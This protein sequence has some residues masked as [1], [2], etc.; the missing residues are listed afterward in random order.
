MSTFGHM[1]IFSKSSWLMI[2]I[3]SR[4]GARGPNRGA[5]VPDGPKTWIHGCQDLGS[6]VLGLGTEVPVLGPWS[7]DL[8]HVHFDSKSVI[9]I[10][11]HILLT[12]ATNLDRFESFVMISFFQEAFVTFIEKG[13][14]PT[15]WSTWSLFREFRSYGHF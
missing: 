5:R 1:D 6:M 12:S 4:S 2:F 3:S 10:L 11:S 9:M 14:F 7:Q 13:S 15:S 8:G